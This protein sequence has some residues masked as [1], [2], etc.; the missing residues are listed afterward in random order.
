MLLRV[1]DLFAF[2]SEGFSGDQMRMFDDI[3]TTLVANIEV[4]A[5]AAL[6]ARIAVIPH[7][8]PRISR[9]LALDDNINVAAPIL[10]Q[11]QQLD[12]DWLAKTARTRSQGHLL[13]ISRRKTLDES[14]TD[15]LLERGNRPVV[16]STASNPGAKISNEGFI[17]LLKR[18]DGDD[19]IAISVGLRN[20]IPRHH[21]LRLLGKATHAVRTKLAT[22]NP[23]MSAVIQ[24]AVSEVA[25]QIQAKTNAVSRNYHAAQELIEELRNTG[26]LAESDIAAFAKAGKFEETT[27]ALAALCH[28]PVEMVERAMV[29]DRPETVLI[30]TKA[31]GI[32]WPTVKIIL[33]LRGGAQGVS[34]HQLELCL[35]TFSRLKPATARQVI[36]FQ[37]KRMI[38]D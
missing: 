31:I 21:L 3:F 16:L 9:S 5:R 12:S 19:E 2:G 14:V 36:D 4:A 33:K 38:G 8:P 6:S 25:G 29:Q 24:Q 10:E 26:R 23:A 22:A 37:R 27:A 28:L 35:G 15:V 18:S 34:P 20:D 1:A 30:I 11:S 32:S 13:A 7:A 17:N